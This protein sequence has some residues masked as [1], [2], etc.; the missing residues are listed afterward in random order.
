MAALRLLG[1]SNRGFSPC[2]KRRLYISNVLPILTYGAQLWWH[3]SWKRR[4]WI[5]RALGKAQGRAARWITGG[6]RTTPTGALEMA[7]G[8]LPIRYQIDK[9]MKRACLRV[10]TLHKGHPTRAH[11]PTP[12]W[13]TDQATNITPPPMP[14]RELMRNNAETPMTHVAVWGT[15]SNEQFD[16]LNDECRLRDRVLDMFK[17]QVLCHLNC[18]DGA[19][20]PP[21]SKGAQLRD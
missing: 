1:N 4:K 13:S 9:Y 3:T 16:I 6:F 18:I 10:R 20:A 15:A 14:L 5:L 7:A 2:D 17:D 12:A 21:K 11:L 19:L 8:L